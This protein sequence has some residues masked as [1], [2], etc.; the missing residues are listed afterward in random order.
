LACGDQELADDVGADPVEFEQV[1]VDRLDEWLD[2][3]V[4]VGDLIGEV[5]V[6]A[7]QAAERGF[8]C[9]AWMP[10]PGGVGA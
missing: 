5:V 9:L 3:G 2:E 7:G 8:G 1:G 4:E 10:D 6:V